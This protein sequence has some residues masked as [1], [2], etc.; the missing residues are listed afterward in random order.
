MS[1]RTRKHKR[2]TRNLCIYVQMTTLGTTD[3]FVVHLLCLITV[4]HFHAA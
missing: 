2:D 4:K 3:V 1:K